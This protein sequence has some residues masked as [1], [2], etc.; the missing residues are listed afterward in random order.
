MALSTVGT[1]PDPLAPLHPATSPQICAPE[2]LPN[3]FNTFGEG[4]GGG[5][6][7]VVQYTISVKDTGVSI[8]GCS[9][10]PHL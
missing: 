9:G 5:E 10:L 7:G 8:L 4:W 2:P 1:R 3:G 6:G